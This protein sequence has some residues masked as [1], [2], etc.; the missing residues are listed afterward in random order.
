MTNRYNTAIIIIHWLMALSFFW[1]FSS[2]FLMVNSEINPSLKFKFYQWHKASGV[3]LLILIALRI[4]A[5]IFTSTPK[6]TRDFSK[7]E[8]KL[9]KI[10][11]LLLYFF[12]I[13]MPLTGWIMV[14]SSPYGLP[15]IVF[16]LFE[17]PHI[18]NIASNE[19]ISYLAKNLHFYFAIIFASLIALH[20]SAVIKHKIINKINLI[21]RMWWP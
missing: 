12:M 16:D 19:E 20:I 17:W 1:M 14:S 18:P 8:I 15:T 2:G 9:A 4:I 11:Y 7:I 6:M 5:K 10:N 3:L 13:L 21:K